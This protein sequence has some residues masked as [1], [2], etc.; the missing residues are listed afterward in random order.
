MTASEFVL[1]LAWLLLPP[2]VLGAGALAII[3]RRSPGR[4]WYRTAGAGLLLAVTSALL[5]VAFVALGPAPLG[6]I[7]GAQDA[8]VMWAPFAFLAVA[9]TFP[10]AVWWA[11]RGGRQ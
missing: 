1:L 11:R 8:P 6:R 4:K 5:A 2:L 7:F 3:H 10:L 9:V